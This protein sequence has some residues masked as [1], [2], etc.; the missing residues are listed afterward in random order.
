MP[1]A[2]EFGT[3]IPGG[4]GVS[5][6]PAYYSPVL[7]G[8]SS[9][10]IQPPPTGQ[11]A[12]C[13]CG[14]GGYAGQTAQTGSTS[15]PITSPAAPIGASSGITSPQPPNP[16]GWL[17]FLGGPKVGNGWPSGGFA[18]PPA[19]AI[20]TGSGSVGAG[21]TDRRYTAQGGQGAASQPPINVGG[22]P[23]QTVLL[24]LLV[25]YGAVKLFE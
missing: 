25:L 22:I 5:G 15:N 8:P 24:G 21:R 23:L 4:G 1:G 2:F 3:V 10:G 20:R 7:S 9:G 16:A 18:T 6:V 14:G 17:G 12:S 13:G 19:A 11:G